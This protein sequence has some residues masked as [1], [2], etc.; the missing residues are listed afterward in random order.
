MLIGKPIRQ[1][2]V[3]DELMCSCGNGYC[4]EGENEYNCPTD[5]ASIFSPENILVSGPIIIYILLAFTYLLAIGYTLKKYVF[6][7]K[8]GTRWIAG[9]C[10]FLFM[11]ITATLTYVSNYEVHL[12]LAYASEAVLAFYIIAIE[13]WARRSIYHMFHPVR[14]SAEDIISSTQH[15]RRF[16]DAVESLASGA[17]VPFARAEERVKRMF[18]KDYM[19]EMR[20]ALDNVK[21]GEIEKKHLGK[22]PYKSANELHKSRINSKFSDDLEDDIKM[23]KYR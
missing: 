14:R 3:Y 9:I 23:R 19:R 18:R 10:I 2:E 8:A 21:M 6:L 22:V 17:F 5:C 4:G 16:N 12:P 7:A 13:V 20:E 15:L 11:D 1:E